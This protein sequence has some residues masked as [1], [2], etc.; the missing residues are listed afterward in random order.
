MVQPNGHVRDGYTPWWARNVYACM[1]ESNEQLLSG[2]GEE[3]QRE[4]ELKLKVA[5]LSLQDDTYSPD[6]S[7]QWSTELVS[8]PKIE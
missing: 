1:E 3:N 2:L 8:W 4:I 5:G 7:G 6:R